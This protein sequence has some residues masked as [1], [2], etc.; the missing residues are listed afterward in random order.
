MFSK[1]T[2]LILTIFTGLIL[3]AAQCGAAQPGPTGR[4]AEALQAEGQQENTG[5]VHAEAHHEYEDEEHKQETYG[6]EAD[7]TELAALSLAEGEKL[8]VVATTSI[9]GDVVQNVGGDMIDLT[10]L[11]PLGSDPHAFEPTPRDLVSVAEAHLVFINGLGL[12]EFLAKMLQNAGSQ[13]AVVAVSNGADFREFDAGDE[14]GLE[15]EGEE[16]HHQG[17]DPHLWMTP[18]NVVVFVRN[19]EHALS[20]LDPTNAK[21]YQA[22]AEAYTA[23]LTELDIWIQAQIETIPVES[24]KLVTD[25]DT[26]GYYADRYG[27]EIIG[28]VLPAYSTNAK[29]SA[30]ELAALQNAIGQSKIKAVFVGTTVNPALARQVAEDTGLKLVPL[31][32]GSL[33]EPGSGAESYLDYIRFNTDAIVEALK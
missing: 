28:A 29:P 18:V 20:A 32:T 27:L 10:V 13:A 23:R 26:F 21:A 19:I 4:Q 24:R 17:V 30:Q 3:V 11:L 6:P 31:Y 12:E 7:V 25:H 14:P 33:G 2:F 5:E 8:K 15:T 1:T 22:N 9:I 16:H